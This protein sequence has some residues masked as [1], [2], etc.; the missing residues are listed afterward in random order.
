MR[1]LI[2]NRLQMDATTSDGELQREVIEL[3]GSRY[4]D[5][6]LND[7]RN[8][9]EE[10][11]PM[12]RETSQPKAK[13]IPLQYDKAADGLRSCKLQHNLRRNREIVLLK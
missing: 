5:M 8:I 3:Y 4:P 1:N 7:W 13:E 9:I 10:Y 6:S 2:Y 11:T 12:V